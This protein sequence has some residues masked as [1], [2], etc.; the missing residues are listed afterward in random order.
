DN[1][2]RTLTS[3]KHVP[4][5][6]KNLISLGV[7]DSNGYKFTG[8]EGI[9]KVFKGA[10]VVM[11]AEKVGNLYRLKGSTQVSEAAITSEK[12]EAGTHLWHQ[13]LGHM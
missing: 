12:K 13:R 9:L 2:V 3:V 6:K 5:L 4:D 8:Q 11:K 7:L 1:T 10:L